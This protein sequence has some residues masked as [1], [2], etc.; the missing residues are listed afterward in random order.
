[1]HDLAHALEYLHRSG[2]IHRDI[3]CQNILIG[4]NN[5]LKIGDLGLAI[6][7]NTGGNEEY[8][9]THSYFAPEILKEKRFNSKV[10]I[11]ALGCVIHYLATFTHPFNDPDYLTMIRN[12]LKKE[13]GALLAG[14]SEEFQEAVL[15]MLCKDPAERPDAKQLLREIIHKHVSITCKSCRNSTSGDLARCSTT[16]LKREAILKTPVERPA[17]ERYSDEKYQQ[18]RAK[19]TAKIENLGCI[20]SLDKFISLNHTYRSIICKTGKLLSNA[21]CENLLASRQ[22]EPIVMLKKS[23]RPQSRRLPPLKL[24]KEAETMSRCNA[25]TYRAKTEMSRFRT[26]GI[27]SVAHFPQK[28]TVLDLF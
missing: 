23:S 24:S 5:T 17:N 20:H 28:L 12:I 14:Y 21:N 4:N 7:G 2:I 25:N 26:T 22:S 6:L 1:M 13:P 18:E 19:S 11:W 3:K 16:Q 9:G 15:K 8:A 10:D 27:I